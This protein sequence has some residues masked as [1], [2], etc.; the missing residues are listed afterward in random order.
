MSTGGVCNPAAGFLPW[1][2]ERTRFGDEKNLSRQSVRPS[3]RWR[4]WCPQKQNLLAKS[5][6]GQK[7]Q[8][9]AVSV[10]AILKGFWQ[11]LFLCETFSLATYVACVHSGQDCIY[12]PMYSCCGSCASPEMRHKRIHRFVASQKSLYKHPSA[13]IHARTKSDEVIVTGLRCHMTFPS[14]STPGGLQSLQR[15]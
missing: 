3:L 13:Y 15:T 9:N 6:I 5:R 1:R 11:F 12:L 8:R 10:F 2:A 7:T 14:R 4:W